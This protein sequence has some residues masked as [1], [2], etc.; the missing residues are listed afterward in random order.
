MWVLTRV[1]DSNLMCFN[2]IQHSISHYKQHGYDL[3]HVF[4]DYN[5]KL[6]C[7]FSLDTG[8]SLVCLDLLRLLE[9]PCAGGICTCAPWISASMLRQRPAGFQ[10]RGKWA[11]IAK[12]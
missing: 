5:R 9:R 10:K 4:F 1:P 6:L 2:F 12:L 3:D 11:R 8:Y 7:I